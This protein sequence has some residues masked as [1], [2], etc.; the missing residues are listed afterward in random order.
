MR[1]AA[2]SS[3]AAGGAY[4]GPLSVFRA[5]ALAATD[6]F[7]SGEDLAAFF[8]AVGVGGVLGMN[9]LGE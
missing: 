3:P 2:E 9:V 5:A 8:A 7:A 4:D 6:F 1:W